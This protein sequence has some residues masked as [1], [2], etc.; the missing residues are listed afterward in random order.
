MAQ[1]VRNP[2]LDEL[3][4]AVRRLKYAPDLHQ[5]AHP[6]R[7][8]SESGYVSIERRK[9]KEEALNEIAPILTV[10]RGAKR[11]KN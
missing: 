6:K 1:A 4:E 10:V 5:A 11:H 7:S 3:A 2:S 8:F 9:R